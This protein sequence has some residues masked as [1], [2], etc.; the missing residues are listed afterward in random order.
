M[1]RGRDP[2]GRFRGP[3]RRR[4][5]PSCAV[6]GRLGRD[7]RCRSRR[8]LAWLAK[9][10]AMSMAMP[11]GS[12]RRNGRMT[13]PFTCGCNICASRSLAPARPLSRPGYGDRPLSGFRRR[14]G[15][16]RVRQ[17]GQ[18]H[19]AAR[20]AHRGTPDYF[21]E[22][23]QDWGLAPLSPVAMAATRAAPFRELIRHATTAGRRAADR[24]CDGTVAAVPDAGGGRGRRRNLCPLSAGGHAVRPAEASRQN[25]T[26]IIGE[27]LGNVP[28]LPR[29]DGACRILSY[30]IFF[31]E[32]REDGFI[33]PADYPR[34]ALACL[35]THDLP[36]FRGWWKGDDVALR[37]RFGF[38]S[39]APRDRT[40]RCAHGGT[41]PI[42]WPILSR[43]GC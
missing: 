21:N 29:G 12:W 37:Q 40:A 22:Q 4:S 32:R 10:G 13:S 8:G 19:R 39:D 20:R 28:G 41:R 18:R 23:G 43:Q 9:H 42:C 2:A 30:R 25:R 5:A 35:S 26:T 31:F 24:S 14:R 36:T 11:C 38:I 16:R 34:D 3:R 27:D 6:R 1:V 15:G 33:P 7:G 17:L